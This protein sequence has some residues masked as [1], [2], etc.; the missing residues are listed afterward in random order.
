MRDNVFWQDLYACGGATVYCGLAFTAGQ[1]RIDGR[2][3][4][5]E[6]AYPADWIASHH[7][8]ENRNTCKASAYGRAAADLHNLW[9]AIGNINSS[10]QDKPL[11]EIPGEAHRR[12]ADYCPDFERTK[13][14]GETEAIVEPRDSVKGDM[15]RSILHMTDSYGLPLPPEMP[16]DMLRKWQEEDPRQRGDDPFVTPPSPPEGASVRAPSGRGHPYAG[17]AQ[18]RA[19]PI[20]PPPARHV[21]SQDLREGAQERGWGMNL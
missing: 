7:D 18:R 9:P 19:G 21:A 5:I 3:L 17:D 16:R 14:S 20:E 1:K 8:C 4:T 15:A 10:R 13:G 11:A 6:H 2:K 12:F